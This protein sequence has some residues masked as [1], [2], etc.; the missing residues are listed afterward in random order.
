ALNNTLKHAQASQAD[1]WLIRE[2]E[3]IRLRVADNG[4]GLQTAGP[5]L[6]TSLGLL[7]MRERLAPW[8]ATVSIDNGAL[9]GVVVSAE[10]PLGGAP[11]VLDDRLELRAAG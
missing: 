2:A 5:S 10:V 8:S 7:G 6:P 9:G 4:R 1:V 11:H 3:A